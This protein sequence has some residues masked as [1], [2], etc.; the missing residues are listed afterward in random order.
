MKKLDE[1]NIVFKGLKEG[2]HLFEYE[3]KDD[4]FELFE[5]TQIETGKVMVGVKLSKNEQMLVLE[6]DIEGL[7]GSTCDRCLEPLDLPVSY[8]GR[9]FVKYGDYYD[10]PTEEIVVLPHEAYAINVARYIYEFIVTSLPIRHLHPNDA[11][12]QPGCDAE[13]L[14]QLNHYL[15]NNTVEASHPEHSVTDQRWNMLNKLIDKTNRKIK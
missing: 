12:G 13:M 6:F 8:K 9:I 11:E 15:V 10:E 14:E 3:L 7:V 1:Y 2:E 5:T 4:F